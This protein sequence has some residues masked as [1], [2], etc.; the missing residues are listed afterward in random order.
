MI[1]SLLI[2]HPHTFLR[3]NVALILSVISAELKKEK[4]KGET[5]ISNY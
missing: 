1:D 4:K 5:I 2:L 3:H